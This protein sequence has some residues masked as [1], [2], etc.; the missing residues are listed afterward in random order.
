MCIQALGAVFLPG[1]PWRDRELGLRHCMLLI[2]QFGCPGLAPC[3]AMFFELDG[4][5]GLDKCTELVIRSG[6]PGSFAEGFLCGTVS[7]GRRLQPGRVMNFR[8]GRAG[9]VHGA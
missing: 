6:L 5:A 2:G 7:S 9:W 3:R 1:L 4:L 8:T